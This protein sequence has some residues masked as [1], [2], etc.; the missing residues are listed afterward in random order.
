MSV[1]HIFTTAITL[2]PVAATQAQLQSF[3]SVYLKLQLWGIVSAKGTRITV[4]ITQHKYT[5]NK[6]YPPHNQKNRDMHTSGNIQPARTCIYETSHTR[7]WRVFMKIA[8]TY[9]YVTSHSNRSTAQRVEC[10]HQTI[11]ENFHS[12]ENCFLLDASEKLNQRRQYKYLNQQLDLRRCVF[13][14]AH[15]LMD[16]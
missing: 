6:V 11:S 8:R 14:R 5:F 3:Q 4:R 2:S 12:L 10:R 16:A 15:L 7:W 13:M 9:I 1:A